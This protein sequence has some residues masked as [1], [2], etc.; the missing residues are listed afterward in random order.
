MVALPALINCAAGMKTCSSVEFT[1]V[2]VRLVAVAPS[3]NR[4]IDEVV[5]FVP[6]R[7]RA[8]PGVPAEAWLV[9]TELS[10]TL[11]MVKF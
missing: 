3:E 9:E 6:T 5:K 1:K 11:P 10:P 7:V 4:T 2:G 8:S